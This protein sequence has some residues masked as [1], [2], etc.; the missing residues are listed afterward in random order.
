MKESQSTIGSL[1]KENSF[2]KESMRE[3]RLKMEGVQKKFDDMNEFI[4]DRKYTSIW[5]QN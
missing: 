3:T 1:K 4:N 2:L 5:E